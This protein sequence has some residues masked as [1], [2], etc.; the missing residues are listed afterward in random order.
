MVTGAITGLLVG[1]GLAVMT[2]VSRS[3][4]KR[5]LTTAGPPV[6][7]PVDVPA[8]YGTVIVRR[9]SVGMSAARV[10][11]DVFVDDVVRGQVG[12]HT[13]VAIPVP[14]GP[15]SVRV[16][17]RKLSSQVRT[18]EMNPGGSITYDC[19]HVQGAFSGGIAIRPAA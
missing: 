14:P 13:A 19:E 12:S 11:F 10:T 2:A 7:P 15:H 4:A 9:L 6:P 1:L 8:G 17:R 18:F 16:A 5:R 3:W